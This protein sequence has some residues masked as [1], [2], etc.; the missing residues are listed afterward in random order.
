MSLEGFEG[1]KIKNI[2]NF[3]ISPEGFE[4]SGDTDLYI[5]RHLAASFFTRISRP[6]GRSI[7]LSRARKRVFCYF[8]FQTTA[9]QN[10]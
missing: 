4:K 8:L 9:P 3:F 2:A 6:M 7:D 5:S 1:G 10:R